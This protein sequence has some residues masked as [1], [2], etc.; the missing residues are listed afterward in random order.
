M[1]GGSTLGVTGS[2]RR[3]IPLLNLPRSDAAWEQHAGRLGGVGEELTGRRWCRPAD[4][5]HPS[6]RPAELHVMRDEGPPPRSRINTRATA[7]WTK[8]PAQ[9]QFRPAHDTSHTRGDGMEPSLSSLGTR[10]QRGHSQDSE[11]PVWEV[12]EAA[13]LRHRAGPTGLPA[14]T[15]IPAVNHFNHGGNTPSCREMSR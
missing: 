5:P 12:A 6:R 13:W 3:K 9:L 15:V 1:T 8:I 4:V 7:I 2:R 11:A 10:V 14:P